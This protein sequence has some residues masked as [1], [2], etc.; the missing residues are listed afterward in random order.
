MA[1]PSG[2]GGAAKPKTRSNTLRQTASAVFALTAVVPLLLFLWTVYYLGALSEVQVQVGLGFALTI[3]LLGFAIFRG[4][5]DQMSDLILALRRVLDLRE[6]SPEA[7]ARASA[8]ALGAIAPAAGAGARAAVSPTR[9]PRPPAP[10]TEPAPPGAREYATVKAVPNVAAMPAPPPA[11]PPER[12]PAPE[13]APAP[14][15]APAPERTS[16]PAAEPRA[17]PGFGAIQE[18]HDLSRAMVVLW[19]AEASMYMGR[20]VL[21]SALR[22]P[23]PIVGTLIELTDDGLLVQTDE[24]ERI[25]V[26]FDRLSGITA[27]KSPNEQ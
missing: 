25:A 1:E 12:V 15:R 22:F 2:G 13:R 27:E 19:Q 8:E 14:Q 5:M 7:V 6:R 3:A 16:R 21:V 24:S 4:L 26:P 10:A 17:V 9:P 11:R 18:V 23:R 20:R